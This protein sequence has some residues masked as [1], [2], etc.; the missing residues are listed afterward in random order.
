MNQISPYYKAVAGFVAAAIVAYLGAMDGGLTQQEW[1][2]I[3]LAGIGGS[4]LVLVAPKNVP[5]AP[6]NQAGNV[7]VALGLLVVITIGVALLL[8]GVSF[9]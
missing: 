3:L 4:G 5:K 1:I 9:K 8:F 6:K 2:N 7:D